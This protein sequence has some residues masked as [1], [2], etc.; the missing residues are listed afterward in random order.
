MFIWEYMYNAS[1]CDVV[2]FGITLSNEKIVQLYRGGQ[3]Y[4][5]R[6]SEYPEKTTNLQKVTDKPYHIMFLRDISWGNQKK[7]VKQMNKN[8][9][10]K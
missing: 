3:F 8:V 10:C 9:S 2:L 5:W 6:K 1:A 7:H 4:W